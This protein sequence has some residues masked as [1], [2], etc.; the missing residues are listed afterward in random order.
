[1]RISS[2]KF[3]LAEPKILGLTQIEIMALVILSS[4]VAAISSS[5]LLTLGLI[6]ASYF[7]VLIVSS[8]LGTDLVVSFLRRILPD[9]KKKENNFNLNNLV[10]FQVKSQFDYS[11]FDQLVSYHNRFRGSFHNKPESFHFSIYFRKREF[12]NFDFPL[13]DESIQNPIEVLRN[14]RRRA[15]L[16]NRLWQN[17]VF[18]ICEKKWFSDLLSF[19]SSCKIQIEQIDF[20]ESFL[21]FDK[22]NISSGEAFHSIEDGSVHAFGLK[23]LPTE[24]DHADLFQFINSLNSELDFSI[25]LKKM[26][27]KK[28]IDRISF[29]QRRIAGFSGGD[30]KGE[31]EESLSIEAIQKTLL[32][33]ISGDESILKVQGVLAVYSPTNAFE[34]PFG[35]LSTSFKKMKHLSTEELRDFCLG[36]QDNFFTISMTALEASAI[37]PLFPHSYDN[38]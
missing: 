4:L 13:E 35:A 11:H 37:A 34:L 1:M 25:S 14:E 38:V 3:L 31:I 22:F 36:K 2:S 20:D 18:L 16:Q 24:F 17:K 27:A 10:I 7:S 6:F 32:N 9:Q 5:G 26:S 12:K 15:Y 30:A 21:N 28:S 29:K 23:T 8:F 19:A 33:L